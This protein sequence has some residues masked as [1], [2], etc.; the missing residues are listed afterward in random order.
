[1]ECTHHHGNSVVMV[2]VTCENELVC[3]ECATDRHRGHVFGKFEEVGKNI[4][5]RCKNL[6]NVAAELRGDLHKVS[7]LRGGGGAPQ[8]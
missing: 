5:K 4:R 6:V 1:M 2:C 8:G 7:E 3:L